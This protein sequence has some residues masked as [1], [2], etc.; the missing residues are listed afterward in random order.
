ML[1]LPADQSHLVGTDKNRNNLSRV[2]VTLEIDGLATF[3]EQK[4]KKERI[5]KNFF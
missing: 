3:Q 1:L 5:K 4:K 2:T